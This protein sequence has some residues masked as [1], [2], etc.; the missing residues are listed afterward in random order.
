MCV[1]NKSATNKDSVFHFFCQLRLYMTRLFSWYQVSAKVLIGNIIELIGNS[2]IKV[3]VDLGWYGSSYKI[4]SAVCGNYHQGKVWGIKPN[5]LVFLF[6]PILVGD[7]INRLLYDTGC[8]V[9]AINW[10][11]KREVFLSGWMICLG[12]R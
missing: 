4:S 8:W 12:W 11:L 3:L 9:T 5:T 10:R 2:S 7:I 6:I 1:C